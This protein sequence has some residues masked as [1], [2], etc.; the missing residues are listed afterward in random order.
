MYILNFDWIIFLVHVAG[1][2]AFGMSVICH[3]DAG[4]IWESTNHIKCESNNT[5]AAAA[6]AWW[7]VIFNIVAV[8]LARMANAF[9]ISQWHFSCGIPNEISWLGC[10]YSNEY[11]FKGKNII[12]KLTQHKDRTDDD[13]T[14]QSFFSLN[15]HTNLHIFSLFIPLSMSFLFFAIGSLW[16]K[17]KQNNSQNNKNVV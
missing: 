17:Q 6:A 9:C 15:K 11:M 7:I 13:N 3:L 2:R 10:Q 12:F 5:I 14:F 1:N 4:E 8:K 16:N